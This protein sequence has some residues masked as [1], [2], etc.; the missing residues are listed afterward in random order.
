MKYSNKTIFQTTA[1][2]I[3]NCRA[4]ALQ[5]TDSE[6]SVLGGHVRRHKSRLL[7]QSPQGDLG[8]ALYLLSLY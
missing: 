4:K 1:Q 7:A 3:K 8:E 2:L 6:K 5:Q